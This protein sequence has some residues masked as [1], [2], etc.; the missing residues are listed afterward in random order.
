M[1]IAYVNAGGGAAASEAFGA[2][3]GLDAA[4]IR[5]DMLYG[6]SAGALNAFGYSFG[7]IE[8]MEAVWRGLTS[9][10][11]LFTSNWWVT[12]P[13]KTGL[14]YPDPLRKL[15]QGLMGRQA[16]VP[17]YSVVTEMYSRVTRFIPHTDPD[18]LEMTVA[19]ARIPGYVEL[20]ERGVSAYGDGGVTMNLPLHRAI[21][22]GHDV[23]I[24]LHCTPQSLSKGDL[25]RVGNGVENALRAYDITAGINYAAERNLPMILPKPNVRIFD[26]F[27][28]AN[29]INT[30]DFE[31][32]IIAAGIDRGVNNARLIVADIQAAIAA[33][34]KIKA[35]SA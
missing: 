35:A 16:K 5:P 23:I 8:A 2:M 29:D 10:D 26:I 20:Y 33:V 32:K 9:V 18:I 15:L 14:R 17:F 28:A 24:C 12:L 27:A 19:S 1:S 22:D 25:W 4:G 3:K 11:D 13:W 31:P 34:E 30:L 7:G 21:A 6:S